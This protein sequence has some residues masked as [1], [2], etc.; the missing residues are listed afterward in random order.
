[1][2]NSIAALKKAIEV[3]NGISQDQ[4]VKIE[5]DSNSRSADYMFVSKDAP[6]VPLGY[7]T[8]TYEGIQPGRGKVFS[9]YARFA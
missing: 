1:M 6:S 5:L 2:F 4:I 3:T 8:V 9:T 7:A